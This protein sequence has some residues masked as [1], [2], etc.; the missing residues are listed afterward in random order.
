MPGGGREGGLAA[1]A[2]AEGEQLLHRQ[3]QRR[4]HERDSS[5]SQTRKRAWARASCDLLKEVVF[6]IWVAISSWVNPSTSWSQTTA[7][8]VSLSLSSALSRSIRRAGEDDRAGAMSSTSSSVSRYLF[9]RSRISALEEVMVR[10]QPQ[11]EPS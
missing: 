10:I 9:R 8:A 3:V 11:S 5:P 1:V 6:P 7:R 4:G 2:V